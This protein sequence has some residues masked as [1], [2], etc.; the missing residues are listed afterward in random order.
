MPL[1]ADDII[2][3]ITLGEPKKNV[4]SLHWTGLCWRVNK[5]FEHAAAAETNM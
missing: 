3:V 1:H 5:Q 4:N 2:I